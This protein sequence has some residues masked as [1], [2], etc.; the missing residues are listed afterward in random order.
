MRG[1]ELRDN[2]MA[3]NGEDVTLTQRTLRGRLSDGAQKAVNGLDLAARISAATA[4]TEYPKVR[5]RTYRPDQPAG[6]GSS[7]T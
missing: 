3:L 2:L 1:T 7:I 6:T 5:K 4:A